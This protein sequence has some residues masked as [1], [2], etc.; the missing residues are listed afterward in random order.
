MKREA[1]ASV[2]DDA[3]AEPSSSSAKREPSITFETCEL[4][5]Y[6]CKA[7]NVE[8]DL[9]LSP[10]ETVESYCGTTACTCQ[11]CGHQLSICLSEIKVAVEV[12]V[13]V[14]SP[15][16]EESG[17]DPEHS[18]DDQDR[19]AQQLA[20]GLR[21]PTREEF[22]DMGLDPDEELAPAA[23]AASVQ[24]STHTHTVQNSWP[25]TMVAD[26]VDD[27][28][29]HSDLGLAADDRL[30]AE[31]D[32]WLRSIGCFADVTVEDR[33]FDEQLTSGQH[34]LGTVMSVPSGGAGVKELQHAVRSLE[35][36]QEL[37]QRLALEVAR[38]RSGNRR[39]VASQLL[40]QTQETEV[41]FGTSFHTDTPNASPDEVSESYKEENLYNDSME[42]TARSPIPEGYKENTG[43]TVYG[44]TT[45]RSPAWW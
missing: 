16:P 1:T 6:F 20:M 40:S 17:E 44:S 24:D 13:L 9:A 3:S 43:R 32:S 21:T 37:Q 12:A 10:G 7:G 26:D 38:S 39:D 8:V 5:C 2:V 31:Q 29:D 18:P 35:V 42:L 19:A 33:L 14:G 45:V 15:V 34:L 4:K 25:G 28:S 36:A 11:E 27:V 41:G 30:E 23:E 22:N